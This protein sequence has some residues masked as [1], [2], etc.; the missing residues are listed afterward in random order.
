MVLVVIVEYVKRGAAGFRAAPLFL[1]EWGEN[2]FLVVLAKG[3]R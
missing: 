3:T 1:V 2:V